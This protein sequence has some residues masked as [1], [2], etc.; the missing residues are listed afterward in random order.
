MDRQQSGGHSRPAGGP[1]RRGKPGGRP[2]RGRGAPPGPTA[3][4]REKVAALAQRSGISAKDALRVV[5]GQVT[6]NQVLEEMFLRQRVRR[7]VDQGIRIDLAGQVVRGRL[8]P[9]RARQC[10]ELWDFQQAGFKRQQWKEWPPGT[11]VGLFCHGREP[12]EVRL[13]DVE[14]YALVV[15]GPEGADRIPKDQVLGYCLAADLPTARS[16]FLPGDGLEDLGPSRS[17]ADRWRP[18]VTQALEWARL[19]GPVRFRL[20]NGQTVRGLVRRAALFGIELEVQGVRLVLM[21]HALRRD[22]PYE[23]G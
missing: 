4:E 7:M 5:R 23:V 11:A 8:P 22:P 14:R 9:D 10:Q 20:R 1:G 3:A 16:F 13:L 12:F 2:P 18:T 19:R 15:E 6:L 21:T 17:L